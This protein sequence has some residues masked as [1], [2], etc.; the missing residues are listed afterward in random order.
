MAHLHAQDLDL[1]AFLQMCAKI[2]VP[3][4]HLLMAFS[5]AQALFD[6]YHY[7]E[8]FLKTTDQG[9]IFITWGEYKW[10]RVGEM[11]R[12]V[13]LGDMP[14]LEGLRDFSNELEGLAPIQQTHILWGVRTDLENEWIESKVSPCFSYPI[15]SHAY[16]RGRAALIVEKWV[17]SSGFPK[18]ARYHSIK[19]IEGGAHA[20]G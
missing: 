3:D 6:F 15:T 9:R 7:N 20:A 10:R 5:P 1:A 17:D 18:F 8:E 4:E 13:Y 14:P 16:P 2:S 11:M 12:V 19:E